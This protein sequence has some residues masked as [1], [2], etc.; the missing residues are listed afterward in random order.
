MSQSLLQSGSDSRGLQQH[1]EPHRGS[2]LVNQH[3]IRDS[4]S[5]KCLSLLPFPP[6]HTWQLGGLAHRLPA[7]GGLHLQSPS[8]WGHTPSPAAAPFLISRPFQDPLYT[9]GVHTGFCNQASWSRGSLPG[10]ALGSDFRLSFLC[11]LDTNMSPQEQ[12][13]PDFFHCPPPLACGRP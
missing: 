9:P 2:V 6:A 5:D 11:S 8:Q 7:P 3:R 1:L 13:R 10:K 12:E 4:L